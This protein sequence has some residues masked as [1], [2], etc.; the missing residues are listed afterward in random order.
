MAS[1]FLIF[2]AYYKTLLISKQDK[3]KLLAFFSQG[4][5]FLCCVSLNTTQWPLYFGM[6]FWAAAQLYPCMRIKK[7]A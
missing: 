1:I 3:A 7:E 4:A 5:L 6:L 2:T